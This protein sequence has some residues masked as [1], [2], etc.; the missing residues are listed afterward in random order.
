MINDFEDFCTCMYAI[1]D[2]LW[3]QTEPLFKRPGPKPTC[4]DSEL[5]TLA[6]V[7][8]CRGWDVVTEILSCWLEHREMFPNIPSQSCFNRH[9]CNWMLAFNLIWPARD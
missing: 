7:G 1:I 5:R 9:R 6:L 2:D 8:E 3:Q 4:R